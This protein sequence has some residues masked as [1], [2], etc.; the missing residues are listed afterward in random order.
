MKNVL[1]EEV[2]KE[3]EQ[4]AAVGRAE[5]MAGNLA[6]AEECF[7]AAWAMIPTPPTDYDYSQILGRGMVTFYK[8][9]KQF[10]KAIAWI[11]VLENAYDGS[12]PST[13]FLAATIHYDAGDLEKAFAIFERLYN[14]YKKRPFSGAPPEYLRFYLEEAKRRGNEKKA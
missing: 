1:G 13:D 11:E 5:W 12:N 4:Q 7:L 2:I 8:T 10:P 14:A 6:S 9:T 3:I